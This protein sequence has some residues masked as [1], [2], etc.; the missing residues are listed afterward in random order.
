MLYVRYNLVRTS[1]L[2][3]ARATPSRVLSNFGYTRAPGPE[4]IGPGARVSP[5]CIG[6]VLSIFWARSAS[7]GALLRRS[8]RGSGRSLKRAKNLCSVRGPCEISAV[9]APEM[10]PPVSNLANN[11]YFICACSDL[12]QQLPALEARYL[13]VTGAGCVWPEFDS[14]AGVSRLQP[15]PRLAH[16]SYSL[17]KATT[18]KKPGSARTEL[19]ACVTD[20]P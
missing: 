20:V 13:M 17:R 11:Q 8:I 1:G 15:Y 14:R 6:P 9:C 18:P 10:R 2:V 3:A 5:E 19:H 4:C 12:G 16:A 7:D